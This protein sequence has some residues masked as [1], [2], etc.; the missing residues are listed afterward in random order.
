MHLS[1]CNET[2]RP[3]SPDLD[4]RILA[5]PCS[6]PTFRLVGTGAKVGFSTEVKEAGRYQGHE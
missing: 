2:V 3:A 6:Q 5:C 1:A 4:D